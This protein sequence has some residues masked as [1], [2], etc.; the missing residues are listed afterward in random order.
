MSRAIAAALVAYIL[1][2]SHMARDAGACGRAHQGRDRDCRHGRSLLWLTA[3]FNAEELRALNV[4]RT[5]RA[6]RRGPAPA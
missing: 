2:L 4:L 6:P 5:R 3:F 1:P